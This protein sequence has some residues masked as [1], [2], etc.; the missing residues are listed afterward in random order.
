MKRYQA[1]HRNNDDDEDADAWLLTYGDLMTQL[2]AFFI[3]LLSFSTISTI[4]FKEVIISLQVAL[5]G[6]GVLP[7]ARA[8]M[9]D[10]PYS[11]KEKVKGDELLGLKSAF[12]KHMEEH[13]MSDH[14]ETEI[15][16]EGMVIILK[17]RDPPVFFD[18][19]DA[20]IREE[21]YPILDQIGGLIKDLPNDVRVEGHTDI[22]PISTPHFP[23]NWELSAMRATNVLRYLHEVS[24]IAPERLSAVGYGS[25]RPIAPNDT[26]LGMSKNRR[27]EIIILRVEEGVRNQS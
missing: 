4:K 22:R 5:A 20:R 8:I 12:D 2:L 13:K 19:A 26:E 3:L 7:S 27:V 1:L 6:T 14:V 21:A 17:Q 18:T 10:I 15:R 24:G 23:S 25:Y 9:D 16:K 11:V